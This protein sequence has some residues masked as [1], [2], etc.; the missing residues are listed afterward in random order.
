V[1]ICVRAASR[2]VPKTSAWPLV[3]GGA[4]RVCA[5][6]SLHLAGISSLLLRLE[7]AVTLVIATVVDALAH[8]LRLDVNATDICTGWPVRRA[9]AGR[10]PL[11]T[12][13]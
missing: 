7:R 5:A 6:R 2:F 8:A 9:A 3:R 12:R 13:L 4:F 10:T 1:I 11:E